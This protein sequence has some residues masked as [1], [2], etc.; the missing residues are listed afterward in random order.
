[1]DRPAKSPLVLFDIVKSTRCA[2]RAEKESVMPKPNNNALAFVGQIKTE[3]KAVLRADGEALKHAIECGK[4][5]NLAKENVLA[6]K[7]KWTKWREENIPEISQQTASLYMRLAENEDQAAKCSSIR[8][9]DELL[10]ALSSNSR[11]SD[12]SEGEFDS[13]NADRPDDDA[14]DATNNAL[15]VRQGASPDLKATLQNAAVDE[16]CAALIDAWDEAHI[17]QLCDRLRDHF[18][19]SET[20]LRRAP[21]APPLR[22]S[23]G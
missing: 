14:A 18:T 16:V 15:L 17:R 23:Q 9:A 19:K 21:P 5:L 4:Y 6:A 12:K 11:S 20:P 10:R 13:D 1:L 7:G 2:I 8:Q 3:H 22:P